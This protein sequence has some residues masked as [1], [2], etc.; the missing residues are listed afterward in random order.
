MPENSAVDAR[1]ERHLCGCHPFSV[2]PQRAAPQ[3]PRTAPSM[4]QI[5]AISAAVTLS[6]LGHSRQPLDAREQRR[7]C[8]RTAPE[9]TVI[10]HTPEY[11][12]IVHTPEYTVIL[13]HVTPPLNKLNVPWYTP[14]LIYSPPVKPNIVTLH[15]PIHLEYSTLSYTI[16][17]ATPLHCYPCTTKSA[18]GTVT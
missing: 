14:R 6:V 2:R 5:S 16:Y 18:P 15:R 8:P 9:Y 4:H 3:C 11:T 7:R 13:G 1:G 10:V 12:V 17:F